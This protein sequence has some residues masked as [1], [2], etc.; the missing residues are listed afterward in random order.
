MLLIRGRSLAKDTHQ[1]IQDGNVECRHSECHRN[2]RYPD[3]D[4]DI[5][6]GH[7]FKNV[8]FPDHVPA[9][10]GHVAGEPETE[11]QHDQ[12]LKE[13]WPPGPFLDHQGYPNMTAVMKGV[14]QTEKRGC[15]ERPAGH[16]FR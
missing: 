11:N 9:V 8:G 13:A 12:L 15:G 5:A 2:L 7:L 10:E 16:V 6:V 4:G 1:I 14:G 3:G